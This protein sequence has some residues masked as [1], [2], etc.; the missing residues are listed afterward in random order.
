[1][2]RA[3]SGP[4]GVRIRPARPDDLPAVMGLFR[5]LDDLQRGW[6]V[7]SPRATF[8]EDMESRYVAAMADPDALLLVAVDRGDPT[9][10][11]GMAMAHLHRPSSFSDELAVELSS[12]FVRAARRGQGIGRALTMGIGRFAQ[13]AGAGYVTLKSFAQNA[14][15][16]RFW[17]SL[18]FA[19]RVLQLVAP[20]ATLASR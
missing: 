16:T 19:P 5:E 6:R 4:A 10:L 11:V 18:G 14:G 7:F 1:M 2:P 13:D 20:S 15:A 9:G 3:G 8:I 12:V 17:E